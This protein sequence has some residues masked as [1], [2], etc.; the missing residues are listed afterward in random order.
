MK[1]YISGLSLLVLAIV[2]VPLVIWLLSRIAKSQTLGRGK[3]AIA[4]TIAAIAAYLIPFGDV[5]VNSIAMANVCPRAGLR[6]YR[7]AEVAGYFQPSWGE[8]L[9]KKHPYRFMEELVST[10]QGQRV[11]RLERKNNEIVRTILDSPS[12]EYE[13]AYETWR[14]DSEARVSRSRYLVRNRIT[15]EILAERLL[16]N[17]L[18]GWVDRFLVLPWFGGSIQGCHGPDA[19]APFAYKVLVPKGT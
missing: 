10:K 18:P 3:K 1:L 17:P 15:G 4:I 5:T 14:T 11:V 12:A 6:I 8:Y 19:G 2:Y 9:L 7:T 13:E 16:F